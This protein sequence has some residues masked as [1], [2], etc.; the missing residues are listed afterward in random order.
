MGMDNTVPRGK[1]PI[2]A[3][4][5]LDVVHLLGAFQPARERERERECVSALR[6]ETKPTTLVLVI[7]CSLGPVLTPGREVRKAAQANVNLQGA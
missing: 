3:K 4:G 2:P 1:K 5:M 6:Q 7:S